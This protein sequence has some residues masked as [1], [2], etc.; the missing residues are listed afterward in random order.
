MAYTSS[1][2]YFVYC[3]F[4]TV[5]GRILVFPSSHLYF[6]AIRFFLSLLIDTLSRYWFSC[7]RLLVFL[8]TR[9]ISNCKLG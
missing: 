5:S 3:Y 6:S 8:S 2:S 1:I 4:G 9:F 7:L